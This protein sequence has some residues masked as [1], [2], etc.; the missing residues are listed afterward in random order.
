MMLIVPTLVW[1][2]VATALRAQIVEST[3]FHWSYSQEKYYGDFS[4][5]QDAHGY[6]ENLKQKIWTEISPVPVFSG[7]EGSEI[8]Y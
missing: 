2:S 1:V 3:I 7:P 4:P 6:H 5:K 8:L